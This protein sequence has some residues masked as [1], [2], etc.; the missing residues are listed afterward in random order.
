M[1]ELLARVSDPIGACFIISLAQPGAAALR[2]PKP[3]TLYPAIELAPS[4]SAFLV[5]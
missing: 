4:F 5:P 2:L 1:R 3:F